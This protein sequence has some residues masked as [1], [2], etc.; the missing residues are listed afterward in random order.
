MYATGQGI[1][2]KDMI[3]ASG[4]CRAGMSITSNRGGRMG[5]L[6]GLWTT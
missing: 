1:G 4:A 3:V 2:V 6:L 5:M